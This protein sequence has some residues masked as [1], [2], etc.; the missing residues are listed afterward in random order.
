[1]TM[2]IKSETGLMVLFRTTQYV[3]E[4]YSN[5]ISQ[6]GILEEGPLVK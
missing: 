2:L 5:N 4:T 6:V 1:M 3:N